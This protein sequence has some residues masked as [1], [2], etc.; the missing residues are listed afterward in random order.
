MYNVQAPP[1][2]DFGST[3]MDEVWPPQLFPDLGNVPVI[4]GKS[5]YLCG[6]Q[7]QSHPDPTV[8]QL[9]T[10][11]PSQQHREPNGCRQPL[12]F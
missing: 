6:D 5:H 3:Q 11:L 12:P 10:L 7:S 1:L 4:L 9:H 8:L 2:F